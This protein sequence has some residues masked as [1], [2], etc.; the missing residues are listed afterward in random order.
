MSDRMQRSRLRWRCRRGVRE[1]DVLLERFVDSGLADGADACS[2]C[3][4]LLEQP[5]PL[6]IE[7]L[8]LGAPPPRE[9]EDIVERIRTHA[10]AAPG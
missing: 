4:R 10:R 9:L 5:D 6:L 1:L 3:E 7:W 2:D 8:I